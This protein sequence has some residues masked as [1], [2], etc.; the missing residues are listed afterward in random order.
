MIMPRKP[1][2]NKDCQVGDAQPQK[3]KHRRRGPGPRVG[4]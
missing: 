2:P 4:D 1:P 3:E